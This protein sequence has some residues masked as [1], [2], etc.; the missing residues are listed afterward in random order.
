MPDPGDVA[1]LR[2][3]RGTIKGSLT[4]LHKTL[5]DLSRKSPDDPKTATLVSYHAN[6][7]ESL[8]WEFKEYHS[9]IVDLLDDSDE[10]AALTEQETQDQHDDEMANL[11]ANLQSLIEVC[12]ST[13]TITPAVHDSPSYK[14]SSKRLA[15]LKVNL[16]HIVDEVD[17]AP[18]LNPD[19]CLLYHYEELLTDIK[20]ELHDVSTT[21]L[22]SLDFTW[23]WWADGNV[24]VNLVRVNLVRAD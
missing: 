22:L 3:R 20:K 14:L 8:N 12:S 9:S 16:A 6:R 4:H 5:K 15:V 1:A 19:V 10:T 23:R 13:T 24:T 11:T 18:C 7:L 21:L 2:R 17:K